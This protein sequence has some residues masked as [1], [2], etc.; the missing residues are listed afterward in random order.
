MTSTP[1]PLAAI[2]PGPNHRTVFDAAGLRDLAGDI[3]AHGL[4]Y[5]PT[6][7]R[8]DG[9]G[10]ELVDGERRYRAVTQLG[11]LTVPCFVRELT[12]REARALMHGCNFHAIQPDAFDEGGSYAGMM[13]DFDLTAEEVATT[14]QVKPD[15]VRKRVALTRLPADLRS[16]LRTA[17]VP[18]GYSEALANS[19][20]TDPNLQRLAFSKLRDF[21]TPTV[22]WFELLVGELAAQQGQCDLFD[23]GLFEGGELKRLMDLAEDP[24]P[25]LPGRDQPPIFGDTDAETMY[26]HQRFW[27]DAAA[28]WAGRAKPTQRRRCEDAAACL[29]SLLDCLPRSRTARLV[30]VYALRATPEGLTPNGLLSLGAV[31]PPR[32]AG[33]LIRGLAPLAAR[34]LAAALGGTLA[35]RTTHD[36]PVLL[37]APR[38]G[39][40][41]RTLADQ[42]QAL[43]S[44][45]EPRLA[46][47]GD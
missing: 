23:T 35:D 46:A 18:L 5:P 41:W 27:L 42:L 39:Q 20:L 15:H 1:V 38:A 7:R 29:D 12:D 17:K 31:R 30:R 25:P 9:S 11:W 33:L 45:H 21:P 47:D 16:D 32:L 3:A 6:V 44:P 28:D 37:D 36:Q 8:T 19:A 10:Y 13:A 2:R 26:L 43:L 40:P 22:G 14:C 4:T 34:Q 24:D